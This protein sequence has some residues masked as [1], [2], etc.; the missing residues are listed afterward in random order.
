MDIQDMDIRKMINQEI[1]KSIQAA[2]IRV[3]M[4]HRTASK[5]KR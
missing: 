2:C 1:E 3:Q 4:E 5:K